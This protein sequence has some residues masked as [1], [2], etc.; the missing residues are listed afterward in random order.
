MNFPVIVASYR[1][2]EHSI[3]RY[4]DTEYSIEDCFVVE[5][6]GNS[7][8]K[9][10]KHIASLD[11]EY[12]NSCSYFDPYNPDGKYSHVIID[13]RDFSFNFDGYREYVGD[14]KTIIFPEKW[15]EHGFD[16]LVLDDIEKIKKQMIEERKERERIKL[17]NEKKQ[18]EEEERTRTELLK[19]RKEKEERLELQRLKEK[20]EKD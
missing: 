12:Y 4:G 15:K 9:L 16:I 13:I 7:K 5:L 8:E 14:S 1:Q 2:A 17:E 19:I 11:L 10:A 20:Y 6:V 3:D 18:R